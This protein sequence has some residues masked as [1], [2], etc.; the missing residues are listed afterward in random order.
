M[1]GT[2]TR[3]GRSD[4]VRAPI[5]A[6]ARP[7]GYKEWYHFVVHRPGWRLLV[8]L[9]LTDEALGGHRLTPRV[10]V[11][12]QDERWTGTVE[13][14]SAAELDI[15]A[16]LGTLTVG[17]NRMTVGRDGYHLVIDLPERDIRGML[18]LTPRGRRFVMVTNQPAG[19]G[20]MSWLFVPRLSVDGWFRI[21]GRE[22]RLVAAPAYHDHNWGRFRWGD[23][24][25]W[26]WGSVL[27]IG[28]EQ[29][30]SLVFMRMTD[31]RRL[32]TLSQ[33]LYVWRHGKAAVMFRDA[34]V[35]VRASGLLGRAP[36]CTLPPPMR[37]VLGGIASDVPASL[38]I[39]AARSGDSVRAEFRPESFARLAHP[40]EV[41]LD[42]SVVLCETAGPVRALGVIGG[43]D[44]AV[45][46][47]GVFELCHG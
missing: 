27:P 31:R 3:L 39:T 40:S 32:R 45:E 18:R 9:S 41:R 11:I 4:F 47:V 13:R 43:E 12:V 24:F 35:R 1:T 22:H 23:D 10:I 36:D 8:N 16:D 26:E 2:T 6:T 33:A 7:D 29:P 37:L 30:W 14:F 21:G 19:L 42:R 25:G 28:P 46:G 44:F 38:E 15:S 5:M 20:R 17:H 34:S